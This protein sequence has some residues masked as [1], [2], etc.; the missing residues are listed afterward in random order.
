M[1]LAQLEKQLLAWAEW[2]F[3]NQDAGLGYPSTSSI[4]PGRC[5]EPVLGAMPVIYMDANVERIERHIIA[6]G[7]FEPLLSTVLCAHY[8]NHGLLP[9]KAAALAISSPQFK[10]QLR[11]ARYWLAGCF[12]H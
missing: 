12:S 10:Q 1:R 6:M 5:H 8:L 2:H 9:Q 3:K 11:L 7:R 4:A